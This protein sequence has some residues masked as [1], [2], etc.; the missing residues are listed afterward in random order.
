MPA[1]NTLTLCTDKALYVGE[2]PATGW[3]CHAAPVLLIG[4]SGR[5]ALHWG[6][7]RAETCR[8]ALVAAGVEHVFDPCGETVALVYLEPDS[9]EARSLRRPFE[10]LGGVVLDVAVPVAA[11]STMDAYLR[12]FDLPAL[13]PCL[14][15][16]PGRPLDARVARSLQALRHPPQERPERSERIARAGLAAGVQLSPSRFNHLFRAEMGV[17]LR[18]YRV[19]SQVR[20]A[21][22]GLAVSPRLTDAALHGEFADSAHFSRMFRQTFGM[23]PSSVLKPL[24]QV[25]LLA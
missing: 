7:G 4:L 13:L 3:H 6:A 20:L 24:R 12:H 5:F 8:S 17:S 10:Q 18:S 2:I 11:R 22:A 9:R 14:G 1:T 16:D 25:T 23:T 15:G 19:W 21:M